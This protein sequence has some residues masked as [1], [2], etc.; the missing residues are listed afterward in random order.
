M[1]EKMDRRTLGDWG[2]EQALRYL[3]DK[4]YQLL[5]R[6]WRMRE[7]E[8]DLVMEQDLM[9]VFVE[10]KTRKTDRFGSPEE[11]IT[12]GKQK[13]IRKTCLA[14]LQENDYENRDWR[15]DVVAIEATRIGK[16]T[17]LDHYKNAV[18]DETNL[19]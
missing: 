7:G 4:G 8:I 15:I 5:A 3:S 11:S 18:E 14:Y 9:I 6:N 2:E 19:G 17:R 10:V 16:I 1:G 12:P 13:R